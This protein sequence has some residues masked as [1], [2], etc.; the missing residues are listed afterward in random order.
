VFGDDGFLRTRLLPL[1]K[2]LA[3]FYEDFL[4]LLDDGSISGQ[5]G[6]FVFAPSYSP[7]NTPTGQPQGQTSQASV[8]ATM[9]IAAAKEAIA[10]LIEACEEIGVEADNIPKWRAMLAKMPDYM[11][12]DDGAL[13]EWT[14]KSLGENYNHRHES[15][16]YPAWPGFEINQQTSGLFAAARRALELRR[17]QN[18]SAHG[19]MHK[20]LIAARLKMPQILRDCLAEILGHDFIY[21]G[22][23]TSHYPGRVYNMDACLSLPTV[24]MEMLVFSRPGEIELLPAL[25]AELTKGCFRGVLCRGGVMVEELQWD[26]QAAMVRARLLSRIDRMITVTVWGRDSRIHLPAGRSTVLEV[27]TQ[28][29]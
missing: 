13:K 5:A 7:E 25:P 27:N 23:A 4:T 24:V 19:F 20:A 28:R 15:H 10:N 14:H 3:L 2:E 21:A 22:G 16:L 12:N 17:P 9:D 8:N 6:R 11:I 18:Y 26:T 1:M 29:A